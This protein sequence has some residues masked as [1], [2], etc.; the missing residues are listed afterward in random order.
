LRRAAIVLEGG[1]DYLIETRLDRL[2]RERNLAGGIPELVSV[3][4]S[5]RRETHIVEAITTH[6]TSFFRDAYP[7][8]A[9]A[10]T[11]IPALI[12]SRERMRSLTIW[13]GA[14]STGQEPYSIAMLLRD[15]F[16]QLA[17]W[18]L[19]IVATDVSNAIL[20]KAREAKFNHLD[21]TRG[22]SAAQLSKHFK[23]QGTSWVLDR[24]VRNLVELRQLNLIDSW[25]MT[26]QPD[27][28]FLRNVLIYFDIPTKR[29]IL[30]RIRGSIARD[31]ALFLGAS[32]TTFNVADGWQ[33]VSANRATYYQVT[34]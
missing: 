20:D 5:S 15:R 4:R 7:F 18:S 1:K 26:P 8:D 2:A 33:R 17:S 10:E 13:C 3:A 28:V 9:L 14:C 32:E 12:R 34:P 11:V 23:Q 30:D 22:L 29:R 31:G 27:I 21:V 6:E 25:T 19:R 16:P 24:D